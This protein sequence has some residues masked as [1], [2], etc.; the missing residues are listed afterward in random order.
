MRPKKPT[1]TLGPPGKAYILFSGGFPS[2]H[3]YAGAKAAFTG[4]KFRTNRRIIKKSGYA[5]KNPGSGA[6][7]WPGKITNALSGHVS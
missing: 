2:L 6:H 3:R 5:R 1:I 4:L 7:L